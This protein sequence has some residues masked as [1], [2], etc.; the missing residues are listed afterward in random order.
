MRGYE[1]A[2]LGGRN[3]GRLCGVGEGMFCPGAR[4][5]APDMSIP[6]PGT[7]ERKG[8]EEREVRDG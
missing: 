2:C 4:K 3:Q 1:S 8:K 6:A 7:K 5:L